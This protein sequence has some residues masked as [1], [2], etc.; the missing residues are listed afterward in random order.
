MAPVLRRLPTSLAAMLLLAAGAVLPAVAAAVA[1]PADAAARL[2]LPTQVLALRVELDGSGHV[3]SSKPLDAQSPLNAVA[4]QY[5]SKLVFT[6][7]RKDGQPAS[8]STCL[9]LA[10][11][12]AARPDGTF[13]LHLKRAINGPCV[14]S[15]GKA[16]PPRVPR[17]Q[18]GL[19]V[20][21]ANLKADGRVDASSLSTEKAELRVPSS[22]DEARY[23]DAATQALRGTRFE[24]DTVAGQPIPSHVSAPFRF[25]GG[26]AKR[27]HDEEKR[28]GAPPPEDPM[29]SW[30]AVSSVPGTD[31]PKIDFTQP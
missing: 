30:N 7:A 1:A 20:L 4:Q 13:G 27:K 11:A 26:P 9:T 19:V 28:R 14:V 10:L 31:L 16:N 8:S 22:F 23:V 29:P 24:L 15:V 21:G 5:A 3:V 6:P 25:G 12:T 2:P 18:G 17:E